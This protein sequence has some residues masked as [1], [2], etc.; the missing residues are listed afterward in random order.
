MNIILLR[1]AQSEGNVNNEVYNQILDS[2][3][4]LTEKGEQDAQNIAKNLLDSLNIVN[5]YTH[6]ASEENDWTVSNQWFPMI[7][8]SP[9]LRAKQ[10]ASILKTGLMSQ[11]IIEPE[12]KECPLLKERDWANLRHSYK[13]AKTKL[14][15]DKLFDF[16]YRPISGESFSDCY[17]RAILFHQTLKE[18][19]KYSDNIIVVSHGEFLKCY[20]MY[21][22]NWTIEDFNKYKNPQNCEFFV[23]F[24]GKLSSKTP[25][26]LRYFR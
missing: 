1:H 7:F 3:I 17:Q 22:L 19:A 23:I 4:P 6:Y 25:L 10:T 14:E 15:K 9:Y 2:Q 13:N 18:R 8:T 26:T 24:D 21:L 16:F 20:M 11:N 12:F 5:G